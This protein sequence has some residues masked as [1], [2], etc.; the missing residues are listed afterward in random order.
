MAKRVNRFVII[1]A[2]RVGPA[3]GHILQKKGERVEAGASRSEESLKQV[4]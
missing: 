2:G 1:G 4:G 3:V